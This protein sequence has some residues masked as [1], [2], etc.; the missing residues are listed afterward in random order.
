[1]I[2]FKIKYAD[3][4]KMMGGYSEGGSVPG[5]GDSDTVPARLTPGEFVIRKSVVS[6]LGSKFFELLN[7]GINVS[8]LIKPVQHFATGG[9]VQPS[10]IITLDFKVNDKNHRGVFSKDVAESLVQQLQE[11]SM[12]TV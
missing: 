5:V 3:Y 8:S 4:L 10:P 7:G 2:E 11:V 1:M 6:K 9:E 12:V